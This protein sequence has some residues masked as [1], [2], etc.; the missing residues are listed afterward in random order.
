L[1]KTFEHLSSERKEEIINACI[2]EFGLHGYEK[3]TTDSIIQRIGISK[4]GLYEYISSKRELF[5]YVVTYTYTKLYDYLQR[6][7]RKRDT[8]LPK[9]LLDRVHLVSS[10]AIDFYIEHP[11]FVSL[12]VRTYQI[13]DDDLAKELEAVFKNRYLDIFGDASEVNLRFGRDKII[14]ML[15]WLLLKTRYEF[16]REMKSGKGISE[17]RKDYMEN[18]DFYISIM[19]SGVYRRVR[20][21][22]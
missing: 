4:G 11:G 14:D 9:D 22:A 12:I 3:T 1:K 10:Y 18:W 2:L 16:L 20:R 8:A 13:A 15:M 5:V 19:R 17:I 21:E 7:I 6:R